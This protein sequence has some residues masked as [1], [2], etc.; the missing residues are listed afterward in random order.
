MMTSLPFDRS[1]EWLE[2]DGLGGFA[3]GTVEGIRTRRYHAVLLVALRPPT[4]RVALVNGFDVW[5]ETPAGQFALGSNRYLPDV[6][7]PD[8]ASRLRDFRPDP[9]PTWTFRLEDGTQIVAELTVPRDMPV[10][11]ASWKLVKQPEATAP[12]YVRLLVRPLLACR[13][14]HSLH[15]ANPAFRFDADEDGEMIRWHPYHGIPGVVA[16][17]NGEYTH[18]PAW[19]HGFLYA[20]EQERGLDCTEDLASPGA[21]RWDLCREDAALLLTTDSFDLP[22]ADRATTSLERLREQE[23]LRRERLGP[24]LLRAADAFLVRRGSG[25]TILAGYPWSTDWGRDTFVALRGLCIAGGRLDEARQV[26]LAWSEHLSGGLFPNHF[27]D[28][29]GQPAFSSVDASLWFVVA[30]HEYLQAMATHGQTV[31]PADCSA[32]RAAVHDVLSACVAS[33]RFGIRLGDDGL[34]AVGEP[35]APATWMDARLG[36]WVVTPR[37][38]KPVEI[39]A[40]WL[41]ALRIG[42]L[43]SNRWQSLLERGLAS[44]TDRFWYHTGAYLYD[45]IDVDHRPGA[46]DPSFRPNQIL[47]VA[48]LPFP[49]L[50]GLYGRRVVDMVEARLWTPLGLRTL[51]PDEAGYVARYDGN[52]RHRESVAHQGPAWP[53]LLGP[54]VEAWVRVRGNTVEAKREARARFLRPLLE[55]LDEAGLGHVSEL[56]DGEPPHRPGGS[57]FQAWSLGEAIRLSFSVLAERAAGRGAATAASSAIVAR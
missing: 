4:D 47:A 46:V 44:F 43:A 31:S 51:A 40:L 48:G 9:W 26:L 28:R 17:S 53:W 38:G 50:G 6:I 11:L 27:A 20:E 14:A 5:V 54:F 56:A 33:T 57:P 25:R 39:Q 29:L 55:H 13:D 23:R 36:E 24:R 7:H 34:L 45:V 52:E 3:S 37:V 18:D 49:L 22:L 1:A 41:N 2:A 12:D 42:A 15:L 30:V 10:A 19:Y 16:V 8:G 35:G 21:L 32:L